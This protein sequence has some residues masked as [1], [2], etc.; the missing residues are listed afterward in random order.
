V[1]KLQQGQP[2]FRILVADDNIDNRQLLTKLLSSVGFEVKE[3]ENGADAVRIHRQWQ[4]HL[5]WMDIRMPKMDGFEAT[6]KIRSI[7]NVVQPIIIALTSHAF[8]RERELIMSSGFDDFV[9]KPFDENHL[10]LTISKHLNV[11]Y[12]YSRTPSTEG[13]KVDPE[14]VHSTLNSDAFK[15]LPDD[16]LEKLKG[17]A[18]GCDMELINQIIG[19]IER[20]DNTLSDRLKVLS[21]NYRYDILLESISDNA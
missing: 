1:E 2:Q 17:A 20:L 8:E 3:A 6:K 21:R 10:F 12:C 18:L 16:L 15:S 5:I 9:S 4:S 13:E 19:E 7:R 11:R 14:V